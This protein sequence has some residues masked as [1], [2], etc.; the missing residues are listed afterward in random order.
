MAATSAA[1]ASF[2]KSRRKA[3]SECASM[4]RCRSRRKP[5]SPRCGWARNKVRALALAA[6]L[7]TAA[8]PAPSGFDMV[9]LGAR[10]GIEDGNLSSYLIRPQGDARGVTCDAGTLVQGLR[11]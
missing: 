4:A 1:S 2:W 6:L 10:G 9:V 5:S 11:V 3:R 7:A 8:A